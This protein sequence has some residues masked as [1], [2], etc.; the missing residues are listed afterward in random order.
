MKFIPFFFLFILSSISVG[1][2]SVGVEPVSLSYLNVV[3]CF[4]ELESEKV[5]AKVDLSKL[6]DLI[7]L[8][9]VTTRSLMLE[10]VAV[11]TDSSDVKKKIR[12]WTTDSVTSPKINYRMQ[13]DYFDVKGLTQEQ[14]IPEK[15]KLNPPQKDLNQFFAT[16]VFESDRY[17]YIDTKLNGVRLTYK[18]NIEKIEE[19]S[20]NDPPQKRQILCDIRQAGAVVCDCIKK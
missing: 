18:K 13:L 2:Q 17:T 10:R 19:L 12:L 15:L 3:R 6:K 9:F 4:P 20:L 1:A 7:D 11:F 8:K 14:I 5:K 16:A